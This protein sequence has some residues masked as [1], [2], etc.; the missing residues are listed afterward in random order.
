MPIPTEL[1]GSLPRPMK[2]QQAYADYDAGK[3]SLRRAGGRAGRRRRGLDPAA[4]GHRRADRLRRRAARLELRHLPAD[5]HAGRHRAGRATSPATA[6]T[7][8]SSTDGHHRQL[9]RLTGGPVPATRPTPPEFVD[10]TMAIA[11]QAHEAGG[12]RARRCCACC[13]RWTARSTGYSREQF[14]A[15]LVRR[16]REGHPPV[17]RRRRRAG[18]DRLHRGPPGQQERSRAT[19]GPGEDMLGEFIDLNNRVLDRFSAEERAQHRH[20]H[21]PGRRLRLDAQRRRRLRASC[22]RACSR[23]TPATS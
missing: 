4:G 22:C 8:P 12:H 9:P 20:P 18:L 16:V 13:T 10:K 1:V 2:L 17:L 5:R 15:D 7:S 14:L 23:S 3:I 11:D 21:L 6:S 19:P